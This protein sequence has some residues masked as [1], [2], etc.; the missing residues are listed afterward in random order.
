MRNVRSLL[1]V[2]AMSVAPPIVLVTQSVPSSHLGPLNGHAEIVFP[3]DPE[4]LMPREELLRHAPRTV[5]ILSMGEARIDPELLASAPALRIA[6]NAAAGFDN[7]DLP[8]MTARG[9][10]ATNTPDSF[11]AATADL[12][13]GLLLA[14]CRRITEGDRFVRTGAWVHEGQRSGRWEGM[15][16][17][18]RTLGI[19][20]FGRIGRAVAARAR[21]FGMSIV[22]C[23]SRPGSGSPCLTLEK[24]LA[25]SDVVSLH[26]P[27]TEESRGLI[28]RAALER[29]KPG[30]LLLN[31]ARGPVVDEDALVEALRSGHLGGAALDVFEREPLVHP[32]LL[33]LEQVVLTPHIGG[34][35]EE[36]RR[37]SR[38]L[39]AENIL[40]VLRG[41]DPPGALNRP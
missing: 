41:Q 10:W 33:A 3:H 16:L 14:L 39:A 27:L 13:L 1:A 21:A 15:L 29:M 11:T 26:T 30:A 34:A 18:G 17:H 36:A 8:S 40:S 7:F 5:A 9:V 28:N 38:I 37:D 19:V 25:V 12:T 31:L 6:A 32:G 2:P 4:V 24:L 22:Y 35:A 23:R 20:G